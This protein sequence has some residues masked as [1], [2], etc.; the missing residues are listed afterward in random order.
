[1][2]RST[3]RRKL[4]WIPETLRYVMLGQILEKKTRLILRGRAALATNDVCQCQ[5]SMFPRPMIN[6][7]VNVIVMAISANVQ[8]DP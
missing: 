2:S 3:A 1:M 8:Q 6:T 4:K 5:P 7:V